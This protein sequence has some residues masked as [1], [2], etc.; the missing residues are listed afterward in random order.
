MDAEDEESPFMIA[1]F[2]VLSLGG[3]RR[4]WAS[5]CRAVVVVSLI[6]AAFCATAE[7]LK[8]GAPAKLPGI[9]SLA[10]SP[11]G[12]LLAAAS[13]EPNEPGTLVV[14]ELDSGKPR[15]VH[16]EPV[17]IASVAFSP[18]GATLAIGCFS[19]T[20]SLLDARTGE[21]KRSLAGHENHV[22]CVAFSADGKTLAT[23]S[24]DRTIKLWDLDSGTALK[25]LSGHADIVYSVAF[26]PGKNQLVSGSSD[27]TSRVWD[28]SA[29]EPIKVFGKS[30]FIVRRAT[31]S[32]DGRWMVE[33]RWDGRVRIRDLTT[34][35][36]RGCIRSGGGIECAELSP[37]NRLLAVCSH[38]RNVKLY[39]VALRD[40]EPAERQRIESLIG[41]W[42]DD[43]YQVREAAS[44]EL[45]SLGMIVEPLLRVCLESPATE[46]RIRSRVL[47]RQLLSP[48]PR[49]SLGH[50]GDV[51]FVRFSPDGR[52]LA[53]GDQSGCVKLWDVGSEKES[54]SFS[55]RP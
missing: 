19:K 8:P 16:E 45:Q 29:G 48:E 28:L 51:E 41:R 36:L 37:D 55:S 47:R 35:D 50:P 4:V 26:V 24:Y 39:G 54:A 25:T 20:A 7:E 52:L 22:R 21:T 14:W 44:K 49:A 9:R 17:G 10:F 40:P 6:H 23:A 13:G 34:F 18:D 30:E 2:K 53:S 33:S 43:D 11:D 32:A 46:V 15:F 27:R 42:D 12:K 31:V 5:Q 3:A 1:V 38:E